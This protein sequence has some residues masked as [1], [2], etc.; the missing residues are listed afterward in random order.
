VTSSH[1]L[2]LSAIHL[3]TQLCSP[4]DFPSTGEYSSG[5]AS[6][7]QVTESHQLNL[8][9]IVTSLTQKVTSSTSES[10]TF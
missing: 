7:E 1:Q 8:K 3:L 5:E 4:A 2:N 9:K 10:L 6:I